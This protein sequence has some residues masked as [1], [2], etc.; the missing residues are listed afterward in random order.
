MV[1]FGGGTQH[2]IYLAANEAITGGWFGYGLLDYGTSTGYGLCMVQF[3]STLR[4]Y[5]PYDAGCGNTLGYGPGLAVG[6][7]YL[8]GNG[9]WCIGALNLYYYQ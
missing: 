9:G 8:S 4:T 2:T 1:G 5:G 7:A 3:T 6:L